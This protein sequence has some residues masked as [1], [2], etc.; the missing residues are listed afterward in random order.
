MPD[1][2]TGFGEKGVAESDGHSHS[3][4]DHLLVIGASLHDVIRGKKGKDKEQKAG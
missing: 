2:L 4:D 1:F 3:P